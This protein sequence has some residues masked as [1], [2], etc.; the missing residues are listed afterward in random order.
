[1]ANHLVKF[2]SVLLEVIDE[3]LCAQGHRLLS[4]KQL[5][6]LQSMAPKHNLHGNS[7]HMSTEQP[8]G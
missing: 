2:Q 7:V 4:F 1:M 3:G 5:R 6:K 8:T